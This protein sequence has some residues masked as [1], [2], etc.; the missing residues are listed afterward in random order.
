MA[1]CLATAALAAGPAMAASPIWTWTG[2]YAGANIGYSWGHSNG[3]MTLSDAASDSV[4]S[5][6]GADFSLNGVIGGGQ[7]G[8]NWQNNNWVYGLEA[9]IQ[10]SAQKGSGA[11]ACPGGSLAAP[12]ASLNSACALGHLGDTTPF[13]TAAL[14]VNDSLSESLDWFG[15]VRGRIG[16]TITPTV[17]GYVTGGLAYGDVSVTN[18]VSGTNL[19]G[20][21]GTNTVTAV[22]VAASM[23]NTTLKVGWTVGCGVEGVITGNWTG[24]VEYLYVDLGN[25]S[26]SFVTPV[27]APSGALV[28][29]GYNSHITDNILRVGFN[30]QF[31]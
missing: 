16:P 28:A 1:A 24:K 7:I 17:F 5:T 13:N 8:Y 26:G 14:P 9:D 29:A 12:P 31:H 22:P 18:T 2:F 10:G 3:T 19:I 6:S 23:S 11:T 25:V 30:Y 15:T 27:V 20:P 21:Q 4:L